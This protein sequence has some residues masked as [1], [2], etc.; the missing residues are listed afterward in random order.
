[1]A[2]IAKGG[3]STSQGKLGTTSGIDDDEPEKEFYASVLV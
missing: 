3:G 2:S 1:M